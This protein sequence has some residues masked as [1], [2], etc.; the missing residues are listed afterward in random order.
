MNF[1]TQPTIGKIVSRGR[2]VYHL[3]SKKYNDAPKEGI[4]VDRL[5][6]IKNTWIKLE[7]LCSKRKFVDSCILD[8][9]IYLIYAKPESDSIQFIAKCQVRDDK[10]MQL[11]TSSERALKDTKD[12]H[13]EKVQRFIMPK[14]AMPLDFI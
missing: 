3:Y 4:H 5:D 6:L 10:N 13:G 14:S 1:G 7:D 11:V 12:G 2:D 8:D 9:D